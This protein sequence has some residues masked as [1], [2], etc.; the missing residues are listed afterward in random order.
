MVREQRRP[1][2][3]DGLME[4]SIMENRLSELRHATFGPMRANAGHIKR[5]DHSLRLAE[6]VPTHAG[7]FED[8]KPFGTRPQDAV[9]KIGII[10]PLIDPLDSLSFSV[11]VEKGGQANERSVESRDRALDHF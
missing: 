7:H 3:H 2:G 1:A 5:R 6:V 4:L 10:D 11:R 8:S 9:R